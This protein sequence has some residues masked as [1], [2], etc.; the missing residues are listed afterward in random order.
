MYRPYFRGKQ[1]EL[2]TVRET[3]ELMAEADFVPIIE[4]V[5]ETLSNLTRALDA[6]CEAEGRSIVIVNPR[7][8]D[9][10]ANGDGISA[11][12]R[13]AYT[14]SEGILAGILLKPEMTASDGLRC[15]ETHA[16]LRPV[17]VH[18]GFTDPRALAHRLGDRLR[19]TEH[20]F[21]DNYC[22][23]PYTRH[24]RG[25]ERVLIRDGFVRRKNADYQKYEKFSD[26]HVI[27][28]EEGMNGFGD[29][30]IVGD[31]YSEGGGPAYAVA[32]HITCIDRD[33]DDVMY[34]HHFVSTT[35]NTPTDPAG[36]FRQALDKLIRELDSGTSNIFESEAI[37][38]F[39]QLHREGHFPG[40]GYV[41][42]LAMKHHIELLADY[43]TL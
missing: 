2:L 1:F 26:L 39:R 5:R 28:Q 35:N 34:V 10:A 41:K 20:I 4:P 31:E 33:R 24:F 7:D 22:G 9:H 3:A 17:F 23:K 21:I 29:F 15:F 25:S 18:A 30:L 32:I 13:D 19:E 16:R 43:L 36:K 40:L 38:E 14:D 42:K 27:Y 12:L 37:K 6:V 8:G 11:L